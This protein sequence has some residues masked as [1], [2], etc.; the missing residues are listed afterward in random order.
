MVSILLGAYLLVVNLHSS[1]NITAEATNLNAK[2]NVPYLSG[3]YLYSYNGMD[4]VKTQLSDTSRKTVL[5]SGIK[6]PSIE[7]AVWAG[8]DGV[9]LKFESSAY[10]NSLPYRQL[11]SEGRSFDEY[12]QPNF[13]YLRFSDSSLH[14][15]E[16]VSPDGSQTAYSTAK[17]T[18]YYIPNT[19]G[20]EGGSSNASI[21]AFSTASLTK[22]IVSNDIGYAASQVRGLST[23]TVRSAVV[24]AN[25]NDTPTHS[26]LKGFSASGDPET[27]LDIKGILLPTNDPE[28]MGGVRSEVDSGREDASNTLTLTLHNLSSGKATKTNTRLYSQ[29]GVLSLYGN[30]DFYMLGSSISDSKTS[31]QLILGGKNVLGQTRASSENLKLD[32]KTT[33]EHTVVNAISF[34]NDQ[35]SM[36]ADE[37]NQVYFTKNQ[38]PNYRLNS[39]SE[40]DAKAAVEACTKQLSFQSEY[41]SESRTFKVY[42]VDDKDFDSHIKAFSTC[43]DSSQ[44]RNLYDYN[45]YF[46]G[47][48]ATSGRITTD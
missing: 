25:I 18:L 46:G 43:V 11:L 9:F 17:K 1:P 7:T 2:S 27:F 29:N 44:G 15:V 19:D 37:N 33:F 39:S 45:F 21:S 42:I 20:E 48:S 28:I 4:F 6:L 14:L 13:W 40:K 5:A 24:C 34:G 30:G 36:F 8:D 31:T 47:V 38:S 35:S 3:N 26:L 16:A 22:E 32:Q 12:S 10:I 23:C 41:F